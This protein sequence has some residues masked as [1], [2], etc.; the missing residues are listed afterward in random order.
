[1]SDPDVGDPPGM[2]DILLKNILY[3]KQKSLLGNLVIQKALT[4][5]TSMVKTKIIQKA[6]KMLHAMYH[7]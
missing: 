6:K 5:Y 3:L 4:G 7:G 1:M 2:E